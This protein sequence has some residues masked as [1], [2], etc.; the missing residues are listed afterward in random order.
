MKKLGLL[1]VFVMSWGLSIQAQTDGN[2]IERDD[3]RQASQRARITEGVVSGDLTRRETQ[4][5]I[6]QQR[7]I[8]RTERRAEADGW[9]TS[10]EQRLINRKQSAASRSIRRQKN[11]LNRRF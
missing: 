2:G 6:A 1:L 5:L 7:D 8:R 11:D 9:V 4:Y 3:L 10:R